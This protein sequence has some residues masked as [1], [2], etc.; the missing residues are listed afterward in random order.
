MTQCLLTNLIIR[1]F[2]VLFP[3]LPYVSSAV[4][5]FHE[6]FGY[7]LQAIEESSNEVSPISIE[8]HIQRHMATGASWD[9]GDRSD[10]GDRR[11][12]GPSWSS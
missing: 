1:E 7:D 2:N 8:G 4:Y 9:R 3:F 5:R 12:L 11:P 6:M 10:R